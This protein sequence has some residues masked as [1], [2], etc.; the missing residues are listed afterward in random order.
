MYN[1][2]LTDDSKILISESLNPEQILYLNGQEY[3][4]QISGI[5]NLLC[6]NSFTDVV[7]GTSDINIVN[8]N[9]RISINGIDWSEWFE[10][11]PTTY[12][13]DNNNST[14]YEEIGSVILDTSSPN[15]KFKFE[16][17]D[18]NILD[19][20]VTYFLEIKWTKNSLLSNP[21]VIKSYEAEGTWNRETLFA[22]INNITSTSDYFYFRPGF[23]LKAFKINSYELI[24]DGITINRTLSIDYRFSQD[25]GRTW[26]NWEL[27]TNENLSTLK[28]SKIRFF[29]PEFRIKR[30]GDISG[31][32]L[33]YDIQLNGD[34]QNVSRDY[35]K[36]NKLGLRECCCIYDAN[37]N[38]LEKIV[39]NIDVG[40]GAAGSNSGN[41]GVSNLLMGLN[42]CSLPDI[43]KNP[44]VNENLANIFDPYNL[45][46]AVDLYSGLA[47]IATQIFGFDVTYFATDPDSNGQDHTFHEYQ[48]YNVVCVSDLKVSVDEN[49]FPDNQ[50][51][52]NQYDLSLF[53]TFEVHI[54]KETFHRAFGISRRPAKKD[55]LWFCQLNRMYKVEHSQ[56]KRDFNNA[57]VYYRVILNKFTQE[58]SIK[59]SSS[60][61]EERINALTKNTTLDELMGV[62]KQEDKLSVANKIQHKTL[63]HDIVRDKIFVEINNEMID[64]SSLIISKNNYSMDS[65][66]YLTTAITYNTEDLIFNKSDNR[67]FVFWFN[68]NNFF[69]PVKS[70]VIEPITLTGLTGPSNSTVY[71]YSVTHSVTTYSYI[72]QKI[73]FIN[74]Y[75]NDYGYKINMDIVNGFNIQLNSLSFSMTVS[76]ITNSVWYCY[77]ANLDQRNLKVD[78]Y[79][80]KRNVTKESDAVKLRSSKLQL[81]QYKTDSISD[82]QEFDLIDYVM[83]ISG[84]DIKLTNIRIFNDIILPE[85]HDKVLNQNIV[86]DAQY[87]ILADN[88]NRI[89]KSNQYPYN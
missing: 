40:G 34:I 45:N 61:I 58:S 49:N 26:S 15:N 87:L 80:Y 56:V 68:V 51:V 65:V 28:F 24:A 50:I 37:G 79:L 53:E 67:S 75:E 86:R 46:K 66:D 57:G 72:P 30:T 88:S 81:V 64:N 29:L 7:D 32:I 33:L 52:F 25:S 1:L 3:I 23:L 55:F 5:T 84:S 36:V 54:T 73:N 6:F 59:P 4:I 62:E 17:V 63:T 13:L 82:A 19:H 42:D 18:F 44:L 43:F 27:L 20:S 78:Q 31:N 16:G 70:F 21:I 69:E 14:F 48:L 10:F 83:N 11:T 35:L 85:V 41:K 77:V 2:Q 60:S 8:R 9:W 74:N 39:N 76:A 12:N 47:T 89:M 22:P 71:T 38:E